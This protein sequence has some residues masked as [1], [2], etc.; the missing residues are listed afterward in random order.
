MIA[1]VVFIPQHCYLW[2]S[3]ALKILFLILEDVIWAVF[4]EQVQTAAGG[5]RNSRCV[6]RH[7]D[8]AT[9]AQWHSFSAHFT[10]KPTMARIDGHSQ[11]NH[12]VHMHRFDRATSGSWSSQETKM[13]LHYATPRW[14]FKVETL[15]L[16]ISYVHAVVIN[17]SLWWWILS[18]CPFLD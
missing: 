14:S 17:Y 4:H 8:H 10:V 12:G 6:V 5:Q 13:A 11:R 3:L 1:K 15:T 16:R 9:V 18:A 2:N 7:S